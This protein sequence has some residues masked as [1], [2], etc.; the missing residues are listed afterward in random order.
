MLLVT[1]TASKSGSVT[2]KVRRAYRRLG[3][4]GVGVQLAALG[5]VLAAA[6]AL[7]VLL[8]EGR[9]P[10]S[11]WI[12]DYA[13]IVFYQVFLG[14]AWCSGGAFL[15]RFFSTPE[16]GKR[17]RLL[18][19]VTLGVVVFTLLMYAAGAL[20]LFG[21]ELSLALPGLMILIGLG[22]LH[23]LVA[24]RNE[25]RQFGGSGALLWCVRVFGYVGIFLVVLQSATPHSIHHDAAWSHLPI[26]EDYARE[27][28][29][30]PFFGFTPKNLP[31]LSSLLYTWAFL[32]PGLGHPALAWLCAQWIELQLLGFTLLGVSA[33]AAWLVGRP[34]YPG[35]WAVF[36][37]FPGFYVYDSNFGGGSDHVA[38]FFALPTLIASMRAARTLSVPYAAL[39]GLFAGALMH[40]KFQCFYLVLPLGMYLTFRWVS[41]GVRRLLRERQGRV[42]LRLSLRAWSQAPIVYIAAFLV[43]FGPHLLLNAF[44]YKNPLYPLLPDV[45]EQGPRLEGMPYDPFVLT[46]DSYSSTV[47]QALK[48]MFTFSVNPQYAFGEA[49]PVFGSLFTVLS[50]IALL[51]F[52]HKNLFTA[53]LMSSA[54]L[55]LWCFTYRIDRNLQLVL[56]WFVAVT[57]ALVLVAWGSGSIGR[58]A[59]VIA[60]GLQVGWGSRFM[61][62]G[63]YQRVKPFL[64]LVE[65]TPDGELG[66]RWNGFRRSFREVGERL[67]KD[68]TL[69]LHTGHVHLG[70]NRRTMGDWAGWQHVIDYRPMRNAR[71]VYDAYKKVGVTHITWNNL[72]FPVTKQEDAL[73]FEFT[74]H[75]AKKMS[76]PSDVTLWAM[77]DEPPPV[78]DPMMAVLRGLHGYDD[79]LYSVQALG[80]FEEL[81]AHLLQYPEPTRHAGSEEEWVQLLRSADVVFWVQK[82][83]TFSEEA[84]E[85]LSSLFKR[86]HTYYSGYG[87]RAS[88]VYLR[89]KESLKCHLAR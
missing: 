89:R 14:T 42:A 22:D 15:L 41:H 63:G 39:S 66:A 21:P 76:A 60:I 1:R 10:T 9:R 25:R 23:L 53:F 24:P 31:H 50:P 70:M 58:L 61:L 2:G 88:S 49:L 11:W 47:V 26:A 43:A 33:A 81:P 32:V 71:D 86:E 20:G 28:R 74:R 77:P 8:P 37:L 65:K 84:S 12:T 17:E 62:V 40:T 64:D 18:Y 6:I 87:G 4:S 27:G 55:F 83:A 45:F 44:F 52:R 57:G 35:V 38:A 51:K 69:L 19:A 7:W 5:C 80:V 56:P 75:Y 54:A 85:T 73:F 16:C 36:F 29:L 3:A 67:P 46:R 34:R 30:V 59:I 79:G 72:H 48:L 13:K 82:A 78:C 68:A